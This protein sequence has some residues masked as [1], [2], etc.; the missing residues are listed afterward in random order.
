LS[1]GVRVGH[2]ATTFKEDEVVFRA[3][4]PGGTS[5]VADDDLIWAEPPRH[6]AAGSVRSIASNSARC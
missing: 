5:L 4:S 1:N 2:Q 6:R 3:F